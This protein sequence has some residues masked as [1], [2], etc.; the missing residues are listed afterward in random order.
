MADNFCKIDL[1]VTVIDIICT[2]V[3]LMVE[4][5]GGSDGGALNS[6]KSLRLFRVIRGLRV[7]RIFRLLRYFGKGLELLVGGEPLEFCYT[8]QYVTD[9]AEDAPSGLS[10]QTDGASSQE[11]LARKK[12]MEDST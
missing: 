7:L 11:T 9:T 4:I 1:F 8:L 6:A 12:R 10:T 5:Q 2:S 3:Q